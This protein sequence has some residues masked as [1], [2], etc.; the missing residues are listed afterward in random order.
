MQTQKPALWIALFF[1]ALTV[2]G[3]AVAPDYGVPFDE[4]S[5]QAILRQNVKEYICALFGEE[6]PAIRTDSWSDVVRI[7]QSVERDHGQSAYYPMALLLGMQTTDPHLF[8][9]LWHAYT[10]LWFMAGV[11]AAY[12]LARELGLSRLLACAVALLLYLQP[13]FFAEGHY[14]N[15]DVVLLSLVI[16]ELATGARLIRK[17]TL[18][19]SFWF[20]FFG[21]LATNMKIVGA[22]PMVLIGV[23]ALGFWVTDRSKN[24]HRIRYAIAAFGFYLLMYGLLTPALWASPLQYFRYVLT[25]ATSFSRWTG[26]VLFQGALYQP[27]NGLPLPHRYLPVM[28]GLTIPIGFLVLMVV[29][30]V[31]AVVR[32]MRHDQQRPLL[33]VITALWLIPAAFVVLRQPVMYNGWRHFYFIYAGLI[34]L[35]GLGLQAIAQW[36]RRK[37]VWQSLGAAVLCVLFAY[38]AV[39]IVTNHPNQYA[40]YNAL[41]GQSQTEYE[42]DYWALSTLQAVQNLC[43]SL[44]ENTTIVLSASEPMSL[45]ALQNSLK[46]LTNSQQQRVRITDAEQ[47]DYLVDNYLYAR[48]YQVQVPADFAWRFSIASYGKTL[49]SVYQKV[50]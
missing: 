29:G 23:A 48:I 5:E 41:A 4:G 10:W 20:A 16:C 9:I 39:G 31:V 40:Y 27:A 32:W 19:G 47:A 42:T 38:Q 25:N 18:W 46:G 34:A 6:Y 13:R 36:L 30:Q 15:K 37:R 45:L 22:Y 14:N 44:P 2:I 33:F 50:K 49:C 3:L 43:Q 21:A 12:F 7:S 35:G 24:S 17:P 1:I 11:V 8:T 26:V 28:M